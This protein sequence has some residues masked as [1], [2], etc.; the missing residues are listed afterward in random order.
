[1]NFDGQ[2]IYII[3][4]RE[5][6]NT[7]EDVYKIGSSSSVLESMSHIPKG[8]NVYMIVK[9][10]N[11]AKVEEEIVTQLKK[12]K[13]LIH[14]ACIGDEYFQGDIITIINT[15]SQAI[16]LLRD[17][18]STEEDSS[19]EESLY[20][21]SEPEA[22]VSKHVSSDPV[23][24]ISQYIV[25]RKEELQE[26]IIDAMQFY[27]TVMSSA[28]FP[29]HFTYNKFAAILTKHR[30]YEQKMAYGPAFV[31]PPIP[32]CDRTEKLEES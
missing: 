10:N 27:K 20:E 21:P 19:S 15:A 4:E 6:I 24:L 26:E 18:G 16:V 5:F 9:V 32:W 7:D 14:Y 23:V 31:F 11:A 29:S 13:S 30:I 1:M 25:D 8:S 22:E 3:K 2:Y 12:C 28:K 17:E